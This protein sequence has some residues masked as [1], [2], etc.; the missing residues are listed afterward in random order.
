ME[1]N[2]FTPVPSECQAQLDLL[3]ITLQE[4]RV[5][6]LLCT[7]KEAQLKMLPEQLS[8]KLKTVETHRDKLYNKLGVSSRVGLVLIGIAIGAIPCPCQRCKSDTTT[9]DAD[10]P[11]IAAP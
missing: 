9:P 7:K 10:P 1:E 2:E 6:Q 4:L 3:R 11:E 5:W 8:I